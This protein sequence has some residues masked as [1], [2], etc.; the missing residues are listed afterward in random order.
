MKSDYRG[1]FFYW[2]SRIHLSKKA[3]RKFLPL[4]DKFLYFSDL[5]RKEGLLSLDPWVEKEPDREVREALRMVVDGF[6]SDLVDEMMLA[7]VI[8][9]RGKEKKQLKALLLWRLLKAL[10]KG[11]SPWTT[12]TILVHLL[13]QNVCLTDYPDVPLPP[14]LPEPH[15]NWD[16]L[17]EWK[18]Q[19][20]R[21]FV[22]ELNNET[23]G[24]ALT[25]LSIPIRETL[26]AQMGR[27]QY[28]DVLEKAAWGE[29]RLFRSRALNA[30]KKGEQI[31][32]KLKEIGAVP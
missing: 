14:E 5:A 28:Y 2:Y 3:R 17:L 10:Q 20:V 29:Y 26:L 16:F 1:Q 18:S 13:G 15:T 11:E 19:A 25:A 23:L 4:A 9:R 7:S 21:C 31:A 24:W 27:F 22:M 32:L 30:L 12:Q 6:D 8:R